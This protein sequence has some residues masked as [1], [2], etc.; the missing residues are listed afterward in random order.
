[1]DPELLAQIA[2]LLGQSTDEL[3]ALTLEDIDEQLNVAFEEAASPE[4]GAPDMVRLQALTEA[5]EGVVA[6]IAAAEEAEQQQEADIAALRA[7]MAPTAE[8][9]PEDPEGG[10][11]EAE[12]PAP[13]GEPETPAAPATPAEEPAPEAEAE[14][15]QEPIAAARVVPIAR[16]RPAVNAPVPTDVSPGVRITAAADLAGYSAGAPIASLADVGRAFADR[17]EGLQGAR[18]V[19]GKV[20]VARMHLDFPTDRTLVLGDDAGNAAKIHGVTSPEAIKAAGGLCAPVAVRYELENVSVDDRPVRDALARF[21][22]ERGGINVPTSP[23]ITAVDSGV[24][25]ITAAEDAASATKP[26]VVVTCPS[27]TETD[28]AAVY[29]CI[30]IGNF[31]RRTF[32]EL[33]A[34]WWA[35]A[36]AMHART[37][38]G[39]LLDGIGAV[40]TNVTDG[41]NLSA[42]RDFLEAGIR[43]RAARISQ[44]RMARGAMFDWLIPEWML[45]LIKADNVREHAG[46]PRDNYTITDAQIEGWLRNNGI[47]PVW[48]KDTETGEGQI[49]GA[50]GVAALNGWNLNPVTYLFPTG[51]FLFLDGGTLDLGTEIRDTTMNEGNNVRAFLETFENVA[52]VGQVTPLEITHSLCVSGAGSLDISVT[53][54][55]NS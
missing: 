26:C 54:P 51:S 48:Y 13:E 38:E 4:E 21:N 14:Q 55:E 40:S 44:H 39:A 46:G 16:R 50:Q 33:F 37:A 34:Q 2:E 17:V 32:P 29:Q 47:N 30:Q 3:A 27:Y 49:Y 35:L 22:A 41:Q 43:A 24:D 1:M 20:P 12:E 8:T 52:F 31:S 9:E 28:I 36:G 18:G 15:Q 25:V 10:E 6:A 19:T 53:C 42:T 11:P 7:R 5:H 45:A 23:I